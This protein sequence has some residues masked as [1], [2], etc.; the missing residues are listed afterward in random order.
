MGLCPSGGGPWRPLRD[1]AERDD[2]PVGRAE[3]EECLPAGVL[4]LPGAPG[5]GG[6]DVLGEDAADA[7][8]LDLGLAVGRADRRGD[9]ALLAVLVG[10]AGGRA[11]GRAHAV[12]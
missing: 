9:L 6:Q 1:E 3:V 4:V 11:R 10:L 5:N 8:E 12:D 7:L 2:D